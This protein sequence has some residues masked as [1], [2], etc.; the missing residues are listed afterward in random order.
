MKTRSRTKSEMHK[1]AWNAIAQRVR[2]NVLTAARTGRLFPIKYREARRLSTTNHNMRVRMQFP[3]LRKEIHEALVQRLKRGNRS[4]YI[5]ILIGTNASQQNTS[6]YYRIL[7]DSNR[8][9]YKNKFYRNFGTIQHVVN[10]NNAA[11][12]IIQTNKGLFTLM[13]NRTA[14]YPL[15][16]NNGNTP[17]VFGQIMAPFNLVQ[18]NGRWHLNFAPRTNGFRISPH[19]NDAFSRGGT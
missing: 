9:L 7:R 17:R 8:E 15:W 2:N 5:N 18:R 14:Q 10:M 6:K 1:S 11:A 3:K 13:N 19:P 12:K 16:K 4:A